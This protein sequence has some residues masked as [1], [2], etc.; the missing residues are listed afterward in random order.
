MRRS[1]EVTQALGHFPGRRPY[2][3]VSGIAEHTHA[4]VYGDGTGRPTAPLIQSEPVVG[5]FMIHVHRIEQGNKHINV[6]ESDAHPS[7]RNAFT[8]LRSDLAPPAAAANTR[9]P[10]LTVKG[11]VSVSERRVN[12]EMTCPSVMPCSR[13][14]SFNVTSSSSSNSIVVAQP[15]I[16]SNVRHRDA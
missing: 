1:A 6:Q 11:A 7:S 4:S 5:V 14:V 9:T 12:A 2:G 10:F 15:R 13:A 3:R 8:T 16:R